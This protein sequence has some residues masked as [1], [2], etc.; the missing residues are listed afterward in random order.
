[1]DAMEEMCWSLCGIIS[2]PLHVSPFRVNLN[3][4]LFILY[5]P[6]IVKIT[7]GVLYRPSNNETKSLEDLQTAP[8]EIALG[9]DL[10]VVGDFNLSAFD[11]QN[12][13]ALNNSAN[14][15]LL[16]DIVHDNFLTLLVN[17]P[18]REEN[19]LDLVL[20]SDPHI[21]D[22]LTV[23]KPF[24]DHNNAITFSISC[25]PYEP[26]KTGFIYESCFIISLGTMSS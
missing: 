12:T 9:N 15:T 22:N 2:K 14:N 13:R 5:F 23:G 11:W 26:H 10:I 17:S 25:C 24:S 7:F 4:S 18:T 16:L 21:V 3:S 8:Q 20:A 6:I 1:M 19:I